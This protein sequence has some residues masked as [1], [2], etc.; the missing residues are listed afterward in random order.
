MRAVR[1]R[2][3]HSGSGIAL[4]LALA[5]LGPLAPSVAAAPDA[6]HVREA[7]LYPRDGR[8]EMGG[9]DHR[10]F[11]GAGVL[12]CRRSDGVPQK[13][14]AAWLV[15]A[16]DLV[17][18]NAHNFRD[19]RLAVTRAVSDCHF[20]IGGRNYAFVAASLQIGTAPDAQALHITDD[21]ALL[22]LAGPVEGVRPQPV[23]AAPDLALGPVSIPVTMVS[24]GG[25]GNFEG[26]SSLESCTIHFVDPP[27]EDAIRRVRH[28]CND[29]YGG[30]GSGLFDEGGRLVALQSASLSMNSRRPF[31]V[32]F[33]YGSAMLFEG[34][35]LAAIRAVAGDRPAP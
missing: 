4:A 34:A 27:G 16:P 29:G 3:P 12:W 35:L 25:H 31:D 13:A 21:W 33:H 20:Q 32:E 11:P 6:A 15:G 17:V 23:P 14:A 2:R 26:G 9:E 10:R 1:A 5:P 19:R 28:D 18:L 22:R 7:A 30:S 24:P 8:R